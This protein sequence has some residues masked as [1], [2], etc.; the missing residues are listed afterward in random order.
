MLP[1]AIPLHSAHFDAWNS[2][3]T[4]HQQAENRI[5]CSVGWRQSR[6]YKLSHQL[7][8]GST[9]GERVADQ[10]GSGSEDWDEE[11]KALVPK[12]MRTRARVS[13]ADMLMSKGTGT[14]YY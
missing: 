13:V 1:A 3:S 8:S 4:G 6:S 5:S 10:V 11:A 12:E 14:L 9:G 2:S 7:R